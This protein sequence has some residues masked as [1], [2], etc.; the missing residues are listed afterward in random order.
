[1]DWILY[2]LIFTSTLRGN[3]ITIVSL[4]SFE[5]PRECREVAVRV[6]PLGITFCEHRPSA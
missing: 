4:G 3:V 1:M 6:P 5:T 2:L